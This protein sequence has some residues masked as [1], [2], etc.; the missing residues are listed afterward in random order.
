MDARPTGGDA[1]TDPDDH[2]MPRWV[3][4]FIGI[5]VAAVVLFVALHLTGLGLGG[6]G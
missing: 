2:E 4:V 3:K 6:H 5:L 1:G